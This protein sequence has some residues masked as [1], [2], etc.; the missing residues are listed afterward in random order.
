[1]TKRS[2]LVR[3]PLLAAALAVSAIAPAPAMAAYDIFLKLD[4]IVGDSSNDKFAKWIELASYSVGAQLVSPSQGNASGRATGKP[5]CAPFNA[6][7]VVD[8][9]SPPLLAALATGRHFSKGEIDIVGTGERASVFLK[10]ELQDVL[11]TSYQD[12]G[13]EG[14]DN[15]PMEGLSLNF[16]KMTITFT[17]QFADGSVDK[18]VIASINC[19][20]AVQ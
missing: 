17:P 7:K 15:S 19:L 4:D 16:S 5:T 3:R 2:S 8:R 18:A 11:V 20:P 6:N 12:A 1:M 9:A 10:Y 14:G 13:A